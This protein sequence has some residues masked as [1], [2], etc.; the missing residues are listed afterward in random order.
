LNISA[1][2]KNGRSANG[3]TYLKANSHHT[4]VGKMKESFCVLPR[5]G[6]NETKRR[7]FGFQV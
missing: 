3:V 1:E 4:M 7:C 5:E 6:K 2:K